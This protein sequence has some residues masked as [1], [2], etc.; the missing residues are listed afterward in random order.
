LI[1]AL[2][3]N[4]DIISAM[5]DFMKL[6]N[7]TAALEA[8]KVELG[9]N[10]FWRYKSGRLPKVIKWIVTNPELAEALAEDA[11]ALSA[12]RPIV[13]QRDAA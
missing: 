9:N 8:H 3:Y 1:A 7:F 12:E 5:E 6:G 11:R 4:I 2:Q 10:Q 13:G